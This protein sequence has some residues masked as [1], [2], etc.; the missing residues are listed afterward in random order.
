MRHLWHVR[1]VDFALAAV[2]LLA[3]MTIEILQALL[4]AVIISIVALV[5]HASQ[6][7]LAVLGRVP[8]R[9][10]F[11]DVRRHPENHTVPGLIVVRP[12]NDLFFAN[13]AGIHE[14]IIDAVSG[15]AHPVKVVL[16]DMGAPSDL[17]APSAEMLIALHRELRERGI[18]FVLTRMTTVVHQILER[19]DT[20]KE[21]GEDD[22]YASAVE[23]YLSFLASEAG[24][25]SDREIARAS[26]LEAREAVQARMSVVT[27]RRQAS[28]AVIVDVLD[29][30]L[31]QIE[32]E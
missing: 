21:I 4:L 13:A 11:S 1:R 10:V 24:G 2:A 20:R 29:K 26:L 6:P 3:L 25:G 19:A 7:K 31:E 8:K 9:M 28:L 5:W 32:K 22:I 30:E 23:A 17:D 16:A 18:R 27:V 14:A 12:Q 15:S